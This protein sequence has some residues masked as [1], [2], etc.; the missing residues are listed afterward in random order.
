VQGGG[1]SLAAKA[2]SH[3]LGVPLLRLDMGAIFNKYQGETE[4]NIRDTL[5]LADQ[6]SPCVLWL[7]E[8]EKGLSQ[9]FHE[10]ATAKRV[11]GTLLTW[12]AERTSQVFM[13]AT[14]NDISKLPPELLR[15]GRFD[16]IFFVDLP[17][18]SARA[19]ILDIHLK[20]RGYATEDFDCR[21]IA[22][23]CDGFSG[24]ELEQAIVS[25]MYNSK[26]LDSMLKT[27]HIVHA[28]VSTMPLSVTMQEQ[29]GQIREWAKERAVQA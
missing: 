22:D 4:K 28:I 21:Y 2:V 27:E 16:E 15:K 18:A 14:S 1:K 8:I 29:I 3:C 13:V 11:L 17:D 7:D 12:M 10:D 6:S 9:S 25:A 24:A 23:Q 26:S 20:K 5:H 19:Q